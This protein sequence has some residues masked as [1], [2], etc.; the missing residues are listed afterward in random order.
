MACDISTELFLNFYFKLYYLFILKQTRV[1]RLNVQ[2]AD[3]FV[4]L[5]GCTGS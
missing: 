3:V 5:L 4:Y 2:H 1:K